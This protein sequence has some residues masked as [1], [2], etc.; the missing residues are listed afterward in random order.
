LTWSFD[1]PVL[2]EGRV[3]I[4]AQEIL[5]GQLLVQDPQ[6]SLRETFYSQQLDE[7]SLTSAKKNAV[8]ESLRR[9]YAQ[10]N[11]DFVGPSFSRVFNMEI[12]SFTK[13]K[14]VIEPRVRY[15]Y[16]TDVKDQNRIIRFDTVDSPFLPIVQDSVEY[17][18]TQRIIGKEKDPNASPREVLSF[19]LR[20][21]V[22]LSKPFTSAT[23]GNLPGS[24]ATTQGKYTPLVASLRA[25]P[26]QSI[27][28]DASAT[29]GN[30]SH[31]V[32]QTSVSANLVGT[33][34]RADKYL[35]FTWFSIF[36][37]PIPGLTTQTPGSSQL[38]LNTGSSLLHDRIHADVQLNYD[39]TKGRFLEQRYV[40]GGNA[41]CWGLTGEFRRYL[42][43]PQDK[44]ITSYGIAITLK[45]VGTI[46]TH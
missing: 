1:P 2:S 3:R 44:A 38:L 40:I 39:A 5:A 32:D 34:A 29:Y 17:S 14:H 22:S 8:D 24:T 4:L 36:H 33:G 6:I 12:G 42:V 26:Y 13:F 35:R 19:A 11:V 41:S 37:Q 16:T 21:S 25:N 28:F 10:G 18:L 9:F 43:L 23:G 45:N 27:T 31:Q 30:V 46:G 15:T 20:Q 7:A